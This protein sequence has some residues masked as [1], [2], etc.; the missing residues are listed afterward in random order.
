MLFGLQLPGL[1]TTRIPSAALRPLPLASLLYSVP[2][3]TSGVQSS[4]GCCRPQV[5]ETCPEPGEPGGRAHSVC[6]FQ[7]RWR[8][9]LGCLPFSLDKMCFSNRLSSHSA[10]KGR[11]IQVSFFGAPGAP[12]RRGH[13]KRLPDA[14][15][16]ANGTARTC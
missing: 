5:V 12:C 10:E 6:A 7:R 4:S 1:L 8:A 11:T 9:T 13:L 14:R 3:M 15:I 2:S 16:C